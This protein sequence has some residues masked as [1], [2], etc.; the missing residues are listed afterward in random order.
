MKN[1]VALLDKDPGSVLSLEDYIAKCNSSAIPINSATRDPL[2]AASA[3]DAIQR[4]PESFSE[5]QQEGVT[6][7]QALPVAVRSEPLPVEGI[8]EAGDPDFNATPSVDIPLILFNALR[9]IRV[10]TQE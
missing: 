9:M 3:E 6:E 5:V 8:S 10:A 4:Y 7:P 1:G 2:P